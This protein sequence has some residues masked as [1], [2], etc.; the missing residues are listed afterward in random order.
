MPE[1]LSLGQRAFE[2]IRHLAAEIGPRPAG[3]AA[4]QQ[5]FGYIAERLRQWGYPVESLPV[6]FAPHPRFFALFALGG[7]ALLAGGLTLLSFPLLALLAPVFIA[8]LPDLAREVIRRAP[9]SAQSQNLLAFTST[10]SAAPTLLLVAH[11]DSAPA[12]AVTQP[13][14]LWLHQ[15]IMFIALRVAW[16]VAAV[17]ALQL[18]GLK[19]PDF[20]LGLASSAGAL[21]GGVWALLEVWSQRERGTRWS[22]GAHDNASGVGV[23]LALAEHYAAQPPARQRVGFLFTGAEETGLHGAESFAA[24]LELAGQRLAVLNLDMVGAGSELRFVT[25]DG[26]LRPRPTSVRLNALIRQADAEA[27]PI[28]YALRS[29]DYLPFLRRGLPVGALQTSGARAAELA[30][31]TVNDSIEPIEPGA[32]ERTAQAVVKVVA[33]AELQG[34]PPPP[35]T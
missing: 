28:S 10:E 12:S 3:S 30:Y 11:V 1:P 17:A 34:F 31:H 27:Q 18:I 4:E 20:A 19:V 14:L 33:L 22:A 7:V 26:A 23:L 5:A 9:R 29:G 13:G 35:L 2:H 6:T 25:Q 21:T 8:C 15:N 32:L 24:Q 16:A